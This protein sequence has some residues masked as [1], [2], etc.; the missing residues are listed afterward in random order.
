MLEHNVEHTKT[1]ASMED[2]MSR[3]SSE[4]SYSKTTQT[5]A[6]KHTLYYTFFVQYKQKYRHTTLCVIYLINEIHGPNIPMRAVGLY[7]AYKPDAQ[8]ASESHHKIYHI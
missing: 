2:P 6:Y 4:L 1:L 3:K 8:K 7:K 5:Q